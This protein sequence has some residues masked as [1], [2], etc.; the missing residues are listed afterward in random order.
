M[1]SLFEPLAQRLHLRLRYN[2]H[3]LKYNNIYSMALAL[4]DFTGD[5]FVLNGDVVLLENIFEP[6]A[7]ST[8]YTV[9]REEEGPEWIPLLDEA[10]RVREMSRRVADLPSLSG[11]SYWTQRDADIIRNH[12]DAYL[13][14]KILR[15][16][17]YFWTHILAAVCGKVEAYAEQLPRAA[18]AEMDNLEQYERVCREIEKHL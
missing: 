6:P 12:F 3:Y 10:G 14:E 15:K 18:I 1:H 8:Y 5:T 4:P 16:T 17:D 9:H 2:E 13:H 11:V 7:R